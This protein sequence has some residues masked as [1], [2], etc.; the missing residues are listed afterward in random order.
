MI[1]F[2]SDIHFSDGTAGPPNVPPGAFRGAYK[3][4]KEM[5]RDAKA[6]RLEI[7]FLGDIFDLIRTAAWQDVVEPMRPWGQPDGVWT[8]DQDNAAL[9][10]L[11]SISDLNNEALEVLASSPIE[12]TIR[13][14]IPGNHDRIVNLSPKLR[15]QVCKAL[16]LAHNPAR[17]FKHH[18]ANSQARTFARHGHEFDAF[19]FE[20]SKSFAKRKWT[21]IPQRD[22]DMTPIGDL[23]AAEISAK[24]PGA[25]MKK[26]PVGEKSYPELAARLRD[27]FDVRPAT[28]ILAFLG[29]QIQNFNDPE[30]TKAINRGFQEVVSEFRELTYVQRWIEKKDRLYNPFDKADILQF[31][32][33]LGKHV[34]LS[35]LEAAAKGYEFFSRSRSSD[36]LAQDAAEEFRRLDQSYEF[37]DPP[38]EFVLY[39]HT[40]SP[41][42]RLIAIQG[43]EPNVRPRFYLNTGM[44]RPMHNQGLLDGFASWDTLCY[45]VI[46]E[47]GEEWKGNFKC[48]RP[49]FEVWTG[50]LE[51]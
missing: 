36:N 29:Y 5:A 40:H 22:Y 43:H 12:N 23:L 20:G 16:D 42:Q 35:Q 37:N 44:W 2:L 33:F 4:L 34:D 25:V 46:Y 27:L 7:V 13:T 18:F 11:E 31:I 49:M 41:E 32:L 51:R 17:K 14:F 24:L 19:N 6:Q 9:K 26:L 28:A 1:V 21:E 38:V 15:T 48:D 45:T 30:I 10:L 3:D 8:S 47:P 50:G 39:G